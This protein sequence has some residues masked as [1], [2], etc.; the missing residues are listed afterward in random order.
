MMR[1]QFDVR[2]A[3]ALDV[4]N[5]FVGEFA[6]GKPAVAFGRFAAPRAGVDFVNRHWRMEP[7]ARGARR[8]PRGVIP[9]VA[10]DIAD[11]RR[12]FRAQLRREAVG[13]GF[14]AEVMIHAG[15]NFEFVERAFVEPR[16]EDF[17]DAA[18]AAG[19]HGVVRG[20]PRD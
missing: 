16:H 2:V 19:A 7:V 5:Q 20:R 6:I 3:H 15:E 13:I 10:V 12:G 8:E 4:R 11:H 14:Q 18:G 1:H 9:F 17:P